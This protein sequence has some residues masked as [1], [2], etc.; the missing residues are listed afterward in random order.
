MYTKKMHKEIRQITDKYYG[1]QFKT[2]DGFY[3]G[4]ILTFA[5]V[6]ELLDEIEKLEKDL[7][8]VRNTIK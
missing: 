4:R 8:E 1:Q 3:L 6:S 2:E 5:A 7:K